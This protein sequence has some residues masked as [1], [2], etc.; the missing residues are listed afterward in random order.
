MKRRCCILSVVL[1]L[2]AIC[3]TSAAVL[4]IDQ[5]VHEF[6]SL[7]DTSIVMSGRCEL[8]VTG[9]SDLLDGC[10]VELGS[11]DAWVFLR[12]LRPSQVL[13]GYLDQF[14]VGGSTAIDGEN[15]RVVQ[16]EDGTVVLPHPSNITPLEVFVE[17][18]FLGDSLS[19][20]L[21]S[22]HTS[23]SLRSFQ[24]AVSS[25]R[26]KRG[27]MATLAENA[28]GSGASRVFVAQDC[29]LDV[30][31]L[32]ESLDE[33]VSF[34]RVFPWRW[35]GRKGWAGGKEPLVEPVWHYDWDNATTSSADIEYVPMRHNLNW[36]AYSNINSKRDST[37]A[38]GFNEPDR[39]D[40]ANMTVAQAL[41][42]WPNLLASGLRLGAPAPSDAAA[43][44]DWL[45]DFMDEA[46]ARN[47][48]VDFVPVHFYKGGWSATQFRDWLQG[49]FDR[50]GR[51][52]WVTEFNNGANW[53]CCD[54]TPAAQAGII[55]EFIEMLD[56]APF[57]ERYSIYNWVGSNREMV[58]NGSLTQAGRV[59]RNNRSPLA[60]SQEAPSEGTRGAAQ[61]RFE[62]DLL[63]GSGHGN[64]AV[65]SWLPEFVPGR[66][67]TALALNGED[68]F[69]RLPVGIGSGLTFTFAAWIYWE[70]GGDWQRIFD[71]GNGTGEYMFLT[72][73][74]G[75]GTLRF[76]IKTADG[77]EERVETAAL[78]LRQW[79]HVA[80]T[81]TRRSGQLYINGEEVASSSIL[82]KPYQL[83]LLANYLG[84]SQFQ[85]DP[86]FGGMLDEVVIL[87]R[88][89]DD[90]AIR[91]LMDDRPPIVNERLIAGPQGGESRPYSGT[92]GD[93][94]S[95]P[96]V[97][98][99]IHYRKIAGPEWLVVEDDGTLS[100]TPSDGSAGTNTFTIQAT[101]EVGL[102]DFLVMT[103]DVASASPT[104]LVAGP[105]DGNI[106]L[107][108]SGVLGATSYRVERAIGLSGM[109]EAIVS[110]LSATT[111]TDSTASPGVVYRYV[112]VAIG[113]GGE[114]LPSGE[115]TAMIPSGSGPELDVSIV[116]AGIVI[117][118]PE[119]YDD[120]RLEMTLD[121]NSAQWTAVE[122]PAGSREVLIPMI[123]TGAFFR[124]MAP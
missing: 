87:D 46:D 108:W 96:D 1:T 40:Q 16:H 115:V 113:G 124:L 121:L 77:G 2:L 36:N 66:I 109:F 104:G 67:G 89:L 44:L 34:I 91:A 19:L 17:P 99:S 101:D 72:P 20:G 41:D 63:D 59:Y 21:Y 62:H 4:E 103:V 26:L 39:P 13:A 88:A 83:R 31:V 111:F 9:S 55:N 35:T 3:A 8:H 71:F 27:Y 32:P 18:H 47:Y 33:A 22:V 120:W 28:D 14:T 30:S 98:D 82:A 73:R 86:M 70:G 114:S 51:P 6:A 112:V 105:V 15:V 56:S 97:D 107:N 64:N 23:R 106:E 79:T 119:G 69:V 48:R 45:Y 102:S 43:G 42:Q 122:V 81:L 68:D 85:A 52:L 57:V 61:L 54:P 74:S 110:G 53:T 25:F 92:I 84:K 80:L 5:G 38:L 93:A 10:T 49:I 58:T 7:S 65:S 94:A 123:E 90:E 29:D 118:W 117:S 24:D 37:H 116:G 76:A 60:Y 50:T 12:N 78:P 95:D 100:G 11:T 75:G